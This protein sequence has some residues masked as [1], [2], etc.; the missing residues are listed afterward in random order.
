MASSMAW[1][2][3]G[4]G[5]ENTF[6]DGMLILTEYTC[7]I[8]L[9]DIPGI[10]RVVSLPANTRAVRLWTGLD[11]LRMALDT[12]PLF[13]GESSANPVPAATF[14]LGATIL[15]GA[16]YTVAIP[17]DTM[18]HTVHLMSNAVSPVVI[19]VAMVE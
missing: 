2:G 12:T 10:V 7:Q 6:A 15:P 3:L 14:Q 19:L 5:A 17:E 16:W 18:V 11:S 13:P 1:S 8:T 4:C 9:S